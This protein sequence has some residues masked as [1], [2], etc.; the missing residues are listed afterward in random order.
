MKQIKEEQTLYDYIIK[1]GGIDIA[2]DIFDVIVYCEFDKGQIENDSFDSCISEIC[3]NLN[4]KE[5]RDNIA[6]VNISEF[7]EKNQDKFLKLL[8]LNGSLSNEEI[9]EELVCDNIPPI[10][11]GNATDKFYKELK[12]LLLDLNCEESEDEER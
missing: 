8:Q 7:I 2:D 5:I 1:N 12:K 3:K 11:S 6:I 4:I 10:I 9:K